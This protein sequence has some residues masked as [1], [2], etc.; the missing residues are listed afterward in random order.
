MNP[1]KC[2]ALS[3]ALLLLAGCNA[4]LPSTMSTDSSFEATQMAAATA[5]EERGDL[6]RSLALWRT[7][8]S[9][10][11]DNETARETVERL[12][13]RSSAQASRAY[14]RGLAAYKAGN[15]R[16]GDRWMMEALALRPGYEE[17]LERLRL[18]SS[19]ASHAKEGEKTNVAYENLADKAA[20]EKA[21]AAAYL[22][23]MQSLYT[24]GKYTELLEASED[25]PAA[26]ASGS[27]LATLVHDSHLALAVQAAKRKDTLSQIGHLE[28]AL[29]TAGKNKVSLQNQVTRLKNSIGT[30]AY[31]EGLSLMKTDLDG[32]I[33]ALERA[34]RYLSNNLAAKEKLDQAR[35]L[36]KNLKR[37]QKK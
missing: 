8:L 27:T 17:A 13:R 21:A 29:P 31:K 32:A 10:N 15:K 33:V 36:Q 34:S 6:A 30:Q 20:E 9:Y 19:Q 23:T 14:Q 35:T 26:V 28:D 11:P 7:V 2:Y 1:A 16:S 12:E 3:G 5:A 24:S 22:T 4:N 18:S 25:A 37:I